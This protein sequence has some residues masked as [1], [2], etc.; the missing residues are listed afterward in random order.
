LREDLGLLGG[1][2]DVPSTPVFVM[3]SVP[4]ASRRPNDLGEVEHGQSV[5]E[6]D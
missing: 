1:Y 2:R 3:T 5:T 6:I 4:R